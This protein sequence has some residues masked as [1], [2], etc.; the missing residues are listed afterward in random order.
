MQNWRLKINLCMLNSLWSRVYAIINSVTDN[1]K[2]YNCLHFSAMDLSEPSTPFS[3]NCIKE[4]VNP[5]EKI[6]PNTR[7]GLVTAG[8]V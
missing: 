6:D 4:K 7:T 1:N 5:F 2:D 3:R 8:L